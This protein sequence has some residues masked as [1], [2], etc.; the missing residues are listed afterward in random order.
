M[1][2]LE[3]KNLKA[4]FFVEAG[5][6][7]AVDDVSFDLQRGETLGIAGESGCGKSTTAYALLNLLPYPGRI[8]EGQVLLDGEDLTQKTQ[9]EMR[10]I[11]WEEIS[12]VFQ[13]AMNALNP[14]LRISDQIV[15]A[16]I[17]HEDITTDDAY[18]KME[19][20]LEVV[21]V[22]PTRAHNYPHEFS[23]GMKQR[24][25]IAMALV[26]EPKVLIADEPTT[27]LDVTVE[28][29]VLKLL[30]SL[31][32]KFQLSVILITHDLATIAEACDRVA[33]MYAGQIVEFANVV[34]IFKERLHPY[35]EGLIRSVPSLLG[36][37]LLVH[38]PG[39]PPGL[40]FPPSGCRFH[41]RCPI[42]TEICLNQEPEFRE[43]KEK[44]FVACHHADNLWGKNVWK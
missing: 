19:D 42:A 24:V 3:V 9:D 22:D 11:R 43:I 18:K 31:Q 36:T 21:G 6:V 7:K 35:T 1:A 29:Q 30:Q 37:E 32:Q 17:L 23:G 38:I 14:V 27:A 2:V 13:G 26:T 25:M 44:H 16:I 34:T 28:A 5:A 41:P 40:I 39:A 20:I 12:M 4:Y 10:Q 33:I 8:V 15:E